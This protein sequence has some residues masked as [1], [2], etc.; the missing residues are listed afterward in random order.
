MTS[1]AKL[2]LTEVLWPECLLQCKSALDNMG[3]GKEIDILVND[4]DVLVNLSLLIEHSQCEIM[5]KHQ[6]GNCYQMHV[7]KI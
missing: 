1:C 3:S 7:K 5:K 6:S 2:D 4:V